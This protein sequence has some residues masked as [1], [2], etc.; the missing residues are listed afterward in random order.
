MISV[1]IPGYAV[2]GVLGR[3]GMAT[4][5]LAVHEKSGRDVALKVMAPVLSADAG[6]RERFLR[7]GR[8]VA[9][10]S[11][12]NIATV[13]D[14]G[15]AGGTYYIAMEYHPGGDLKSRLRQGIGVAEALRVA[16]DV[17]RALDY[18]HG[19]GYLHRDVK[20]DNI[21]FRADGS[22]VLADFGVARAM[23]SDAGLTQAGV[24]AGTP[25]YMSPEQARGQVLDADADLYSLGVVLFEMLA[26]HLPYEAPD[27]IALGILHMNAPIPR[28]GGGWRTS[29]RCWTACWPSR[30]PGARKAGRRSCVKSTHWSRP[31]TPARCRMLRMANARRSGRHRAGRWPL[32]TLAMLPCPCCGRLPAPVD[33]RL[34]CFSPFFALV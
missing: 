24:V 21:L 11:H 10:I 29:S 22:A 30:R 6:F 9:G 14:V 7:E 33:R 18:A 23:E 13:Y 25:G 26:G 2:K 16:R 15:V 5:Y 19:R 1:E 4:V 28:L 34:F 32:P 17:A 8:I 31:T 27:P 3:G 12:P 20:P